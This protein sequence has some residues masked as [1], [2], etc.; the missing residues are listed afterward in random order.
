MLL[1]NNLYIFVTLCAKMYSWADGFLSEGYNFSLLPAL[2][3]G[4]CRA[5][6]SLHNTSTRVDANTS[7]PEQTHAS[8]CVDANTSTPEQTHASTRVQANTS[9]P[10]ITHKYTCG[11]KHKYSRKLT[12]QQQ[13]VSSSSRGRGKQQ[14][15]VTVVDASHPCTVII[16]H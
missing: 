6:K 9:T 12:Q 5:P 13:K 7:T 8:T 14:A 4:H 16:I 15:A 1:H 10:E 11:C 2:Y 3:D